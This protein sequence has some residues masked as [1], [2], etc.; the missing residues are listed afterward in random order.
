MKRPEFTG[1]TEEMD[2]FSPKILNGTVNKKLDLLM[3]IDVYC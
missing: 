2:H 1:E 3:F